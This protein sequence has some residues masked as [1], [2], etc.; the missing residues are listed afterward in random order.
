MTA[1]RFDRLVSAFGAAPIPRRLISALGIGFLL[2]LRGATF[3]EVA[4]AKKKR[5]KK[6]GG[7][8]TASPPPSSPTAPLAI[9]YQCP[10][11]GEVTNVYAGD[12][13][14]AQAFTAIRTGTLREI[15]LF[16]IKPPGSAG[17]YVVQLVKASGTPP[18]PSNS[19][20]DVIAATTIPDGIVPQGNATLSAIFAG[21]PVF[22]GLAYAVVLSRPGT[23]LG[24]LTVRTRFSATECEGQ[25][26]DTGTPAGP[27]SANPPVDM[28]VTVLVA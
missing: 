17:D 27:F 4:Q 11:A 2:A 5:K 15:Q 14:V 24:G 1:Q 8:N 23:T 3:S 13:R 10:N 20:F 26:A 12:R 6:R 18:L 22:Q 21:T 9:A 25:L 28:S 19:P 16:I 7:K